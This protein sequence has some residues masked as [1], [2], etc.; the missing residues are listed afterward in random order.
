V[1]IAFNKLEQATEEGYQC[2]EVQLGLG[3]FI[4][5][6]DVLC[7]S[8]GGVKPWT[9]ASLKMTTLIL[10]PP[11]IAQLSTTYPHPC[12]GYLDHPF[13]YR[14]SLRASSVYLY[15]KQSTADKE[16]TEI[17]V[18]GVK[19]LNRSFRHVIAGFIPSKL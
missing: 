2:G 3:L 19:L 15:F 5:G 13:A 18:S 1:E 7:R 4:F 6:D 10:T 8:K 9:S 16:L 12:T 14:I 11:R 17:L